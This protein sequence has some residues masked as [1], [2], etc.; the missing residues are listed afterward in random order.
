MHGGN[1]LIELSSSPTA[2]DAEVRRVCLIDHRNSGPGPRCIDAAALEW[3]IRIAD[4]EA[5]ER[6]HGVDGQREVTGPAMVKAIRVACARTATERKLHDHLWKGKRP[7]TGQD[8]VALSAHVTHRLQEA[9]REAPASSEEYTQTMVYYAVRQAGRSL[10]PVV[11]AR[12][13]AW[14]SAQYAALPTDPPTD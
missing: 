5:I 1:V 9:F 14:L 13:C 10:R 11:R 2:A 3:S 12:L 8:W 4:A 7:P 6:E